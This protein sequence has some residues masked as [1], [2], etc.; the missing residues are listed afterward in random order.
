MQVLVKQ[1]T[2]RTDLLCPVCNLGFR[3]YWE[4][5]THAERI[6]MRDIVLGELRDHHAPEN[7]ADPSP[8]AHP[9]GFFNL[10]NWSSSPAP[11]IPPDAPSHHSRSH[12]PTHNVVLI[13]SAK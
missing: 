6:T 8:A 3:L 12:P 1:S 2:S 13:S 10:P 9:E 7:G 11:T 5:S 4:L